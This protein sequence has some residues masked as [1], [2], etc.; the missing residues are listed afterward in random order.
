MAQLDATV[1]NVSLGTLGR[2]LHAG[3]ATIQ[4]VM[5][6]YL[7][8]LA[9]VL[10]LNG[11]LVDR[12]GAR[13]V[14]LWCFATFTLASALCGL[15]WSAESLIAFRVL[16]GTSGGL[17]APMAQMMVARVAGRQM[18]R[19]AS[20][21][22]M[23]VLLAPLL[24]PVVAGGIL[25]YASWRWLFL[26]N[27]PVGMVAFTLAAVLLGDDRNETQPR[28]LDVAGLALLSPGL[29][30]FLYGSDRPGTPIGWASLAVSAVILVMFYRT[31]ARKRDAALIDLRLLRN[32]PF[33]ASVVVMFMMNGVSFAGQMLVPVYLTHAV[34]LSP[35]RSGLLLAPLGL[36]MMC[37]YPF[38]GRLTNRF[39]IRGLAGAGALLALGATLPLI[40]LADRGLSTPL[41]VASLYLR[42]VGISAVG[43]PSM[44]AGYASIRKP[45]L[46]MA[47]TASNIVQ[48]LGGPTMMTVCSTFLGWRLSAG[49]GPALMSEVFVTTFALLSALHAALCLA[50]LRLPAVL[51]DEKRD[52]N[53]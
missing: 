53:R 38:M 34:G 2:D 25:H 35:G 52:Q 45:D 1:V 22:T 10:P 16:Q 47:T 8:A 4:W 14:Y 48:R 50:T 26:I 5:S 13:A 44:S 6:S 39:G 17:L 28:R 40:V 42:G 33:A 15:A 20:Y 19:V 29:V 37:T 51:P 41:L 36:G 27:L 24:G 46:P 12:I 23:P 31:A 32:K 21:V 9:L 18:P 11:W 49:S 7:L 3:L 43:V 30:L